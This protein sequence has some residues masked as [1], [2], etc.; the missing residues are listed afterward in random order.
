M[1]AG[2]SGSKRDCMR[3]LIIGFGSI[4]RRHARNLRALCN[5]LELILLRREVKSDSEA[6]ELKARVVTSLG[7]ALDSRRVFGLLVL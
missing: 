1:E 7:A 5:P 4:G 3:A 6:K 2:A